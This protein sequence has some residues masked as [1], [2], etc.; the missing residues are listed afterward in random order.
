MGS[1]YGGKSENW[2]QALSSRPMDKG[3]FGGS[4][5]QFLA[6]SSDSVRSVGGTVSVASLSR[7][8]TPGSTSLMKSNLQPGQFSGAPTLQRAVYVPQSGNTGM[9]SYNSP[10]PA[11]NTRA[12]MPATG[13]SAVYNTK[14]MPSGRVSY[15]PQSRPSSIAP[16]AMGT[17]QG[18]RSI[19]QRQPIS[20]QRTGGASVNTP[21]TET[22][23][24][25]AVKSV[26]PASQ[27]PQ[28]A[29]QTQRPVTR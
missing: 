6:K 9:K 12:I 16:A 13:H 5:A 7:G 1:P 8:Q 18:Q 20:Y 25:A 23:R 21:R 29:P 27:Q 17:P 15:A 24:P 14:S 22:A 3:G 28:R 11:P 10:S 19:Y 2:I 4:Q 26:A